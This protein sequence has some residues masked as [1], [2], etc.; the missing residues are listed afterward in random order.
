MLARLLLNHKPTAKQQSAST[1]K[2]Y[3]CLQ[4]GVPDAIAAL[5]EAGLR[6]WMITG[7]KQETAI[8][9]GISCGL[10]NDPQHLLVG[11]QL[12]ESCA[13]LAVCGTYPYIHWP[14]HEQERTPPSPHS[15]HCAPSPSR[16]LWSGY[17]RV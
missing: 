7:D 12:L 15:L 17:M 5:I 2:S 1:L 6:V 11:I 8:N 13:T 9:I 16:A 10:I 14:L 4:E 3:L